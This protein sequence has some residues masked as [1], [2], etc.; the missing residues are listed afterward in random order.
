MT[1][2][3]PTGLTGRVVW[4]GVV[5]D[6][7]AGVASTPVDRVQAGFAGLEG[8]AHAGLT[9]PACVRVKRQYPRGTEIRNARQ[10]SIVSAEELAAIAAAMGI[11]RLEPGWL[12]AS[13]MVAGLEAFTR[14]PPAARLIFTAGTGVAVD[15]ENAPCRLPAAEIEA[16]HPGRGRGFPTH[17]RGRRGVVG[18]VERPGPIALGDRFEVHVPP[19]HPWPPLRR[20]AD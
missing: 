14:I 2:L 3:T 11:D 10:L 17:A 1:L 20:P 7:R 15:M 8:E 13:M 16:R 4:L 9:R 18:W 6:R 5:K 12:G 19:Q